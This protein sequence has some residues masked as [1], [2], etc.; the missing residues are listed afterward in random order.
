MTN[1]IDTISTP[2]TPKPDSPSEVW[3]EYAE[4]KGY[5]R[6]EEYPTREALAEADPSKA[7]FKAAH[8]FW[9]PARLGTSTKARRCT[10]HDTIVRTMV[11]YASEH[12]LHALASANR[13][14]HDLVSESMALE[15]EATFI[16]ALRSLTQIGVD[17]EYISSLVE[18]HAA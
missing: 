17:T 9:V 13:D 10:P 6:Q 5:P 18:E 2:P 1:L 4:Y 15:R 12:G 3:V 7:S 14:A 8:G 16:E 11:E